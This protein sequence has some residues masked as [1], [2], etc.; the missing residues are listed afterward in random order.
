[1]WILLSASCAITWCSLWEKKPDHKYESLW[2]RSHKSSEYCWNYQT[3]VMTKVH[4]I[5]HRDLNHDFKIIAINENKDNRKS[6]QVEVEEITRVSK[7]WVDE[8][9]KNRKF[10]IITV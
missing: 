9:I 4:S 2:E 1:M 5:L 6:C 8:I 7:K 3:E 10:Y